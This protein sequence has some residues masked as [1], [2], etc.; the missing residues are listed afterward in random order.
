MG[1]LYRRVRPTRFEEVEGQEHVKEVLQSAI[2][3]GRLA[4]AYLFSGP[5]GVGKTTV[6]RLLAMAVGCEAP[7]DERPC[8]RCDHCRAVAAG[9]HPDVLEIDAASNN[10]VEDVRELKERILLAPVMAPRKVIILDEAHM[11]SKSAFNALLKTLEEPPEHV[12]FIFATTE[13]ERLPATVKS[14][15]QHFRFHRLPKEAI[16]AKL[17]R[18][19]AAEGLAIEDDALEMIAEAA[20]GAMRDAESLLDRVLALKPERFTRADA[21]ALLGLPPAAALAELAEA[22]VA[23]DL[24][25]ARARAEGLYLEGHAPRTLVRELKAVLR[26]RYLA[27]P[28]QGRLLRAALALDEAEERLAREEGRLALDFALLRAH[29]ALEAPPPAGAPQERGE[30]PAEKPRPFAPAAKKKKPAEGPRPSTGPA[31]KEGKKHKPPTDPLA[32]YTRFLTR[33]PA[34]VRAFVRE[35]R[36]ELQGD[37]LRLRFSRTFKFH[38]ERAQAQQER[39]R[40]VAAEVLGVGDVEVVLEDDEDPHPAPPKPP[41]PPA[42]A[43][44]P[45]AEPA[46]SEAAPVP[47]P[48]PPAAEPPRDWLKDPRVQR[49]IDLFGARLK[50]RGDDS[51]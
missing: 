40:A 36:P 22:L 50:E 45:P 44:P 41:S 47:P 23:G 35:A 46:L 1:A 29:A 19:A 24:E 8:G 2:R 7:A 25:A 26:K 51:G 9:N 17:K 32:D 11:M 15:T 18:I 42:Q 34:V 31:A 28:A 13:P 21:E 16:L 20:D 49:F 37:V 4:H 14:R 6:A 38:Y 3:Q 5:R 39:V 43:A 27:A 10:S 33:L 30:K 12:L 48:P